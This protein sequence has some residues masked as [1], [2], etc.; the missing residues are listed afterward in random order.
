MHLSKPQGT[1]GALVFL[2][3]CSQGSTL[4]FTYSIIIK[5]VCTHFILCLILYDNE[6]KCL[7]LALMCFMCVFFFKS[8]N[9]L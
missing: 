9:L 8:Q 3:I 2:W 7:K 6:Y 1:S 5:C 4:Y